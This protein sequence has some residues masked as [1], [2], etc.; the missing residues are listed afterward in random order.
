[1]KRHRHPV[2]ALLMLLAWSACPAADY[3]AKPIRLVVGFAPGGANDLV[4]RAVATRLG[5][6]LRH[7]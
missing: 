6:A 2:A 7:R 1:M 4:A 5:R 3:P